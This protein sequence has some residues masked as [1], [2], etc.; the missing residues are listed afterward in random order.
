MTNLAHVESGDSGGHP[1]LLEPEVFT[2]SQFFSSAAGNIDL[3]PEKRLVLSI[4]EGAVSDFQRFATA[5]DATGR[6]LFRD[7]AAWFASPDQS[8]PFAFESACLW[9][10]LPSDSIRRGLVAWKAE[11]VAGKGPQLSTSP[12]RRVVGS[13]TKTTG[14][15]AGLSYLRA[16]T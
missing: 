12:F 7:A 5:R 16:G 10:G 13:R 1:A 2:P 3:Q 6:R 15:A 14:R 8:W 11:R 9:L 4:L